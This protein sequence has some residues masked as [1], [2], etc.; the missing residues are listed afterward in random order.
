MAKR[1]PS[2]DGLRAV[3]IALVLVSHS[4]DHKA[5]GR[6][7]P[8][9]E[10]VGN[11]SLGV[12]IFFVISGYLITILLLREMDNTGKIA[13]Q[14]F[15]FRR[16]FRILPACYLYLG[17]VLLLM[18]IGY[19]QPA[20]TEWLFSFAFLRD[21]YAAFQ[22]GPASDS[23]TTHFWSLAVEEQFYIFWPVSLAV[24][25]RRRGTWL[26]LGLIVAS[27]MSRVLTYYVLPGLRPDMGVMAHTRADTIMFGCLAALLSDSVAFREAVRKAIDARLPW[28]AVLFLA[29]VSP[30]L[31]M[32]FQGRYLLLFGY[33]LEGVCITLV[34][35]WL[36]DRHTSAA[37]RLMNH[38]AV[39]HLGVISYSFYLWQQL[40][41]GLGLPWSI[42]PTMLAAEGS[43]WFVERPFLK[44]RERFLSARRE[45][46]LPVAVHQLSVS[47]SELTG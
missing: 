37:G 44:L 6:L 13:L 12:S 26:A 8:L 38:R 39:V 27:P 7:R 5:A 43:Y 4:Y 25:G 42:V 11:G 24:L 36:I 15:Y 18:Y 22:P 28:L 19:S 47:G 3:S 29:L 1:I 34:M 35:L 45:R 9:W 41:C 31:L 16:A 46:V 23:Y 40:F 33:S 17:V 30:I 14:A 21:Y 2:L 20:Y 10:I 32:W